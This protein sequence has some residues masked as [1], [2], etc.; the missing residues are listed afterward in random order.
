MDEDDT[1]DGYFIPKG[2]VVLGN[3]WAVQHDPEAYESPESFDP[4]RFLQN[5]YGT[6]GS[7]EE[8]QAEGR[9][10]LYCFGSGRRQCPGDTFAQSSI[11]IA[12]AR[13]VWGFDIVADGDVDLGTGSGYSGGLVMTPMPFRGR[14]VPRSESVRKKI[15]EEYEKTRHLLE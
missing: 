5:S 2:T 3:A 4:D 14:F 9:K 13:L 10:Q 6:R 1:V 8:A 11:M 15:M 7:A 12:M